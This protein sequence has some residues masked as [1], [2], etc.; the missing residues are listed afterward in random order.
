MF[1]P[2]F[3]GALCQDWKLKKK[4]KT[5]SYKPNEKRITKSI[6]ALI[7]SGKSESL[8]GIICGSQYDHEERPSKGS[9]Y[10]NFTI[11]IICARNKPSIYFF[12]ILHESVYHFSHFLRLLC[13]HNTW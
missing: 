4:L 5:I 11:K 8:A 10:N 1:R 7:D 9:C 2:T 6:F 13:I 3:S 12:I